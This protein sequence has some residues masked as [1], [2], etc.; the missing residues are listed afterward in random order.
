MRKK[1]HKVD[2]LISHLCKI[3]LEAIHHLPNRAATFHAIDVALKIAG[4]ELVAKLGG[5]TIDPKL[6][7]DIYSEA[8]NG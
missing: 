3:K 6:V 2:T 4:W 1:R 8:A 5:K 7:K